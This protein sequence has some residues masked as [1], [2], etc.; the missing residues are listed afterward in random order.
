[1]FLDTASKKNIVWIDIVK[2]IG[3]FLVIWG[4]V[5]LYVNNSSCLDNLNRFIYLFHM[6]LFFII[7]GYLYHSKGKKEN[8]K[9]IFWGL[10]IPYLIYQFSFLPFRLGRIVLAGDADI[11]TAF[12]K[13][14]AG[15][16]LGDFLGPNP[17]FY[18]VCGPLWFVVSII[19]LRLIF[20][21]INLNAKNLI[22]LNLT[23]VSI[24]KVLFY[25]NIDLYFC[26]DNTLMAIPYFSLGYFLQK[27]RYF[28]IP[29]K[30]KNI[31]KDLILIVISVIVLCIILKY[32]GVVQMNMNITEKLKY[33]SL[34]L[35]YLGG[36]TGTYM[37]YKF[38]RLFNSENIFVKTIAKNTLFIIFFHTFIQFI[39]KWCKVDIL[40]AKYLTDI[41]LKTGFLL[42]YTVLALVICYFAIRILEKYCPVVLGKYH[43]KPADD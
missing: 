39:A 3:I 35:A 36:I 12:I 22:L 27:R 5:H 38:S 43:T 41:Y 18:A 9:K 16:I 33:K 23:A 14:A 7:A 29:E 28:E 31:L 6:P 24:L 30:H 37:V 10:F 17:H 13:L 19:Q 26:L 8:Y 20:N 1:M 40:C 15:I 2:F 42:F 11:V 4:H 25:F 34:V 21:N 32:N